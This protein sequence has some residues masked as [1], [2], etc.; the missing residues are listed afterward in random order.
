MAGIDRDLPHRTFDSITS[1][2]CTSPDV[3][4]LNQTVNMRTHA[5]PADLSGA[6]I[7]ALAL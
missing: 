6:Q 2:P 7:R 1:R 3:A 5:M 4:S